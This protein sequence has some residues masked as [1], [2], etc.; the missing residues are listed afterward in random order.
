MT[1][2]GERTAWIFAVG[3]RDFSTQG[4]ALMLAFSFGIGYRRS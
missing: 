4:D 2:F 3:G 1:A